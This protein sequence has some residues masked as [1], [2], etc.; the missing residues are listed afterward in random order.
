MAEIIG[1]LILVLVKGKNI[2]K[3]RTPETLNATYI[4]TETKISEKRN[5]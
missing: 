3:S 5:S 4:K 1:T 2:N